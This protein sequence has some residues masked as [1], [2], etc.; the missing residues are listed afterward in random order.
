MNVNLH[1][2]WLC[3]CH[4][5]FNHNISKSGLLSR[6]HS[7]A[8]DTIMPKRTK[9]EAEATRE[10]LL[11]AAEITF[12]ERGVSRTSLEQ[13][14]RQAGMT[15]GAVYWH[16][17][18]KSDLFHAM[19]DRVKMPLRQLLDDVED[20]DQPNAPLES[21]RLATL[22]ALERLQGPRSRRVHTI[23]LHCSES[24][25]DVDILALQDQLSSDCYET[26][27]ERFEQA[28]NTGTLASS[29]EPEI[30]CRMLMSMFLGLMHD[31][32]RDPE[33][34]DIGEV[35]PRMLDTFFERISPMPADPLPC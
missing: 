27:V 18:N 22:H 30:A 20:P 15:R 11:D 14:A 31:W 6:S 32:L 24:A 13:I 16:F 25:S 10:A 9:A 12:L 23:L 1:K 19:L 4:G 2:N 17:K 33:R 34:Y 8:D 29:I 35:G 21:L 28:H 3:S 7:S 26:M 5:G